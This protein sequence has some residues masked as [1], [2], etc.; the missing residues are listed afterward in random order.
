MRVSKRAWENEWRE[1]KLGS[2]GRNLKGKEER[3]AIQMLQSDRIIY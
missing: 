1:R 2:V 3:D